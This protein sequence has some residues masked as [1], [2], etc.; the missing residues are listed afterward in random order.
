VLCVDEGSKTFPSGGY[1][2]S[3]IHDAGDSMVTKVPKTSRSASFMTGQREEAAQLVAAGRLSFEQIATR[4][5][6]TERQ[7]YTWRQ[8]D[9]FKARIDEI[10]ER[11]AAEVGRYTIAQRARRIA[12]LDD[13]W[14]RM[15]D[16]MDARALYSAPDVGGDVLRPDPTGRRTGLIVEKPGEFGSEW[17]FDAALM[18]EM[19]AHE[20]QAAKE[21]GQWVDKVAPTD[22]SGQKSY[23]PIDLA[24]LSVDELRDLRG[25]A[26]KAVVAPS[27]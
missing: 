4:I 14:R 8:R 16:L 17:A 6:I 7:L 20:E 23:E 18:R 15:H 26:E 9:E 13:R 21:L 19:R 24:R 3:F 12:S 11:F 2:R 25:M 1:L 27:D 5:G 10:N 22:P